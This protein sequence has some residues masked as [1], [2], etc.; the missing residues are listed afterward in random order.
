M[1]FALQVVQRRWYPGAVT[2]LL[3]IELDQKELSEDFEKTLKTGGCYVAGETTLAQN[4]SCELEIV[5]PRDGA[6]LKLAARV[7][8]VNEG[9]VGVA[10]EDFGA[11][12]RDELLS[13]VKRRPAERRAPL[14]VHERLRNI[15]QVEQFRIARAG[16]AHER[17][18]LE[19]LYG[20][21]V[22]AVLVSNQR[23]TVPEV[24][25]LARM[26]SMP[27]PQLETI[28][29]NNTWL[30]SPQV[31][32]ALLSNRRLSTDMVRKVLRVTPK[33]EL[34][35]VPMQT[36]YPQTVRAEAKRMLSSR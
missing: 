20:K 10:F 35:L 34:K 36:S 8:M 9:G 16:E 30:Q 5:R 31:R 6:S 21:A 28:V 4:D 29:A 26:G 11:E 32:R 12:L 22:W 23:L 17:I 18:V 3:R 2:S 14:N 1:R 15:S 33:H 7:V 19:R 13:F 24:A 27:R 25:R